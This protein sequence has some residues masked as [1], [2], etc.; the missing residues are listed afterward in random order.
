M[1]WYAIAAGI[2]ILLIVGKIR[3]SRNEAAA[4]VEQQR[5]KESALEAKREEEQE[6]AKKAAVEAE[7]NRYNALANPASDFKYVL[8]D[9]KGNSI[10]ITGYI[11]KAATVVIPSDIEGYP[12]KAIGAF[13]K[14]GTDDVAANVTL[15]DGVIAINF[16]GCASLQTINLPISVTIINFSDCTSLQTINLPDSITNL[17]YNAFYNCTSLTSIVLPKTFDNFQTNSRGAGGAFSGCTSLVAVIIQSNIS[18]IPYKTFENCSAL[19]TL[20]INGNIKDIKDGAFY[21]CDNLTT[22]NIGPDVTKI[23]G[24]KNIPWSKLPLAK[25]AELAKIQY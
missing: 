19:T 18:T 20:N 9:L 4:Q 15:P 16:S 25:Q 13:H 12:V 10:V 6:A 8:D 3:K 17:P 14:N 24:A 2:I 11:G 1:G 5:W 23:G 22:V 21:H 7:K